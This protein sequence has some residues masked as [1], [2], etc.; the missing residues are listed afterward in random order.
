MNRVT[1]ITLAVDNLA[2]AQSFYARL[3]WELTEAVPDMIAFYDLQGLMLGLYNAAKHAED[4]GC[5]AASL[6]TGKSALAVNFAT[7]A[8]VDAAYERAISA[9]ARVIHAPKK[10]FWGGY[11]SL[12]RDPYGHVWEY[13]MNPFWTLDENGRLVD[14]GAQSTDQ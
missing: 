14:T 8:E 12:W 1:L 6:G 2:E 4:M 11:S 9:G 7:E 10:V 3:G 5:D 13:A